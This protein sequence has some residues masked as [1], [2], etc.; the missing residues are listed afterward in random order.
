MAIKAA[1]FVVKGKTE[2]KVDQAAVNNVMY[3][4]GKLVVANKEVK[5]QEVVKERVKEQPMLAK[6]YKQ[7]S[8]MNDMI[9]NK[10]TQ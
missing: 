3:K 7:S 5:E 6:F 10:V 1:N 9:N 8:Y 2:P 4:V